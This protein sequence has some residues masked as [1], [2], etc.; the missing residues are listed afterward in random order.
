MGEKNAK[1]NC[2]NGFNVHFCD[3][4]RTAYGQTANR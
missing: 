3:N 2:K 4:K 1:G